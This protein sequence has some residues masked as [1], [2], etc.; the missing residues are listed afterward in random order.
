[1][2]DDLYHLL[3]GGTTIQRKVLIVLDKSTFCTYTV[4]VVNYNS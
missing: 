1:M 3:T 2:A 4:D